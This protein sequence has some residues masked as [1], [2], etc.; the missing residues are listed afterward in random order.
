MALF[1]IGRAPAILRAKQVEIADRIYVVETE[2][3][4]MTFHELTAGQIR[5]VMHNTPGLSE[6]HMFG[7]IAFMLEGNMCCGVIEDNLVV[8]VGLEAY[9]H[10]LHEPHAR[11][12]DFTGRPLPGFVY[13]DRAGFADDA[14]LKQWID[15]G[16]D[17]VRTLPAKKGGVCPSPA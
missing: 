5:S 10:A 11:P 4:A 12:M 15:R 8:R 14:S 9:Q 6:R 17:F 16:V 13:V 3:G 7:G 2:A 1:C